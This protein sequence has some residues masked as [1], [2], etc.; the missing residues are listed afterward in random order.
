MLVLQTKISVAPEPVFQKWDRKFLA[1][2]DQ[3][4]EIRMNPKAVGSSLQPY[5]HP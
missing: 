3:W 2:V 1:R 5:P 4:V